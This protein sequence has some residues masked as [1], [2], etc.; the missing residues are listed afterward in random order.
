MIISEDESTHTIHLGPTLQHKQAHNSESLRIKEYKVEN[1]ELFY[2][3]T[4]QDLG[5]TELIEKFNGKAVYCGYD[6]TSDS[7][8]LGI[9]MKNFREFGVHHHDEQAQSS[10]FETYLF[11]WRS[12]RSD[13]RSQRQTKRANSFRGKGGRQEHRKS[14]NLNRFCLSKHPEIV[15]FKTVRLR[16]FQLS[17]VAEHSKQL[18]N[19]KQLQIL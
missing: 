18:E 3:M 4:S 19:G 12:H 16:Y 17:I 5:K 14:L 6:P 2:Q 7:L 13:R 9:E 11:G 8:H 15:N 10:G 1:S